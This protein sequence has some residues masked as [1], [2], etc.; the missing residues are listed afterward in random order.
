MKK[1]FRVIDTLNLASTV[2]STWRGILFSLRL[3]SRAKHWGSHGDERKVVGG[4]EPLMRREVEGLPWEWTQAPLPCGS[5]DRLCNKLHSHLV[6]RH[7]CQ[8]TAVRGMKTKKKNKRGP[9]WDGH[10]HFALNCQRTIA[11]S[12]QKRWCHIICWGIKN[13]ISIKK[14]CYSMQPHIAVW[15]S[16]K[17]LIIFII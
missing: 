17:Q 11:K 7:L 2:C 8:E 9:D 12:F 16:L 4:W 14:L 10:T 1:Q 13:S 3:L 15:N 5:I 6:V